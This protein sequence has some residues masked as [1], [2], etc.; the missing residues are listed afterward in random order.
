MLHDYSKHIL[1]IYHTTEY[2]SEEQ[3]SEYEQRSSDLHRFWNHLSLTVKSSPVG[4]MLRDMAQLELQ[5]P[6]SVLPEIDDAKVS[7]GITRTIYLCEIT[8]LLLSN[9]F[10]FFVAA[11][12]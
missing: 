9:S 12:Y 10:Y 3:K 2:I 5:V 11:I 4:S 8:Y 6:H 1:N 7:V